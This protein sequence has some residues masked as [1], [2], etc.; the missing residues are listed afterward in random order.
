M[1][2]KQ[3]SFICL[4]TTMMIIIIVA[5]FTLRTAAHLKKTF[6]PIAPP[7]TPNHRWRQNPKHRNSHLRINQL[8]SEA[9]NHVKQKSNTKSSYWEEVARSETTP[10][11][12]TAT[13]QKESEIS[14]VLITIILL[15]TFPSDVV[16]VSRSLLL[17]E[18]D[19]VMSGEK[20]IKSVMLVLR[21][22]KSSFSLKNLQVPV[23]FSST[24]IALQ[25]ISQTSNGTYEFLNAL[26][27]S[28]LPTND[29][30]NSVS[31]DSLSCATCNIQ[32]NE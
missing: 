24:T 8:T 12:Y 29:R 1:S 18:W 30:L 21:L 20:L 28:Y 10:L 9:Y 3:K 14:A 19:L 23:C 25:V 22:I 6:F 27:L 7:T 15:H 13:C 32:Y 2:E 26:S 11:S 16:A 5:L 31:F 4:L 17:F